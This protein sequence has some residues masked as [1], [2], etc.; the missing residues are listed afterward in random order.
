M[1][2]KLIKTMNR[3]LAFILLLIGLAAMIGAG[4]LAFHLPI[5]S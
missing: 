3:V 1:A 2:R 4:W 5:P